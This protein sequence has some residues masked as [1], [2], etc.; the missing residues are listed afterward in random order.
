VTVSVYFTNW[1]RPQQRKKF[2]ACS[3]I[4][5]FLLFT[6]VKHTLEIR[7]SGLGLVYGV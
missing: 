1:K 7:L 6:L 5:Q 3:Y 4:I 2:V